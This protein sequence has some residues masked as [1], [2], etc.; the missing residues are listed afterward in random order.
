MFTA[1]TN[2][3]P[4]STLPQAVDVVVV[5]LVSMVLNRVLVATDN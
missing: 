4:T 5:T 2:Q 3:L 1:V